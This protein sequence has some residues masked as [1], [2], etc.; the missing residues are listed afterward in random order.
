LIKTRSL[1]VG[2]FIIAASLTTFWAGRWAR[3]N[4]TR[5]P[6]KTLDFSCRD[7]KSDAVLF[8]PRFA[9]FFKGHSWGIGEQAGTTMVDGRYGGF[10]PPDSDPFIFHGGQM[11]TT[12]NGYGPHARET[13]F[14]CF[15]HH[16]IYRDFKSE[17]EV[18]GRHFPTRT[19][20][21]LRIEDGAVRVL[22]LNRPLPK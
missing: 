16:I 1:F 14:G 7:I 3:E 5:L 21:A 10:F 17:V 4:T 12:Y 18:D 6:T 15:R 22:N 8:C 19:F 2:A 11:T 20:L 9:V 13:Q